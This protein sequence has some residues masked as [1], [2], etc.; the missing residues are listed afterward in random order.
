VDSD[1]PG[2]PKKVDS[3]KNSGRQRDKHQNVFERRLSAT[4]FSAAFV[5]I[6]CGRHIVSSKENDSVFA[7]SLY[8]ILTDVFGCRLGILTFLLGNGLGGACDLLGCS[9]SEV[10]KHGNQG[11]GNESDDDYV[12]KHRLSFFVLS[13]FHVLSS[14]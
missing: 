4:V 5:R 2:R 8:G 9:P 13:R 6:E 12:L 3:R 1:L 10:G 14:Y 7:K 11:N